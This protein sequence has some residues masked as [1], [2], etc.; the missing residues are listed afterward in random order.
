MPVEL[1]RVAGVVAAAGLGVLLLAPWRWA[2]LAGL[3]AWG[4]GAVGL[5]A[6]LE[7]ITGTVRL[8]AAAAGLALASAA[9]AA[10]FLRWPWLV[11]LGALALAPAR[12]PLDL[13]GEQAK[14]L[15]PLYV[16]IA[17]A[18]LALAWQLSLGDGRARELGP[19][20]WPVAALV[21]WFGLTLAWSDDVREGAVSLVAFYLPFGLLALVLARLPWSRRWLTALAI[22]LATMGIVFAAI[23]IFQWISRDVFW[24]P[25]VIVGNAYAPFYRVNSVFWDPSVYGRFLVLA[26]L[27]LLVV[28][29]FGR[30]LRLSILAVLAI[31]AVWTGLVFSFSQS[32]FG[33]LIAGVLALG[34]IAWGRKAVLAL[35]VVAAVLLAVGFAAESVRS[36]LR[37]DVDRVTSGRYDLVRNGVRIAADRPASGVGLGSF[38]VAYA[39]HTGLTGDEPRQAASHTTPVTVAAET[40][41]PGLL[42]FAWLV[43]VPLVLGFRRASRSF[44]GRVSL[45]VAL[46]VLA[47]GVH[48]LFYS[49]FF[50]DP[51][52]WGALGLSA[53][54][55][56]WRGDGR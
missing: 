8:T 49:A 19:L 48:S 43:A 26:L 22:Q 20:A 34:A 54:V 5:L 4:A 25:R 12:I 30:S 28:V 18:S 35:A 46:A 53:L 9:L 31:A 16:V 29:L 39:E 3:A 15:V 1:A 7:P 33:A 44:A 56:A 6:Y 40:G 27:M 42:L 50:E 23:G 13:G 2:R 55:A 21:T 45:I 51:M 10:V 47:I 38:E 36:E 52:T 11:A 17:G 14:L 37:R 24:N 32:S 41:L